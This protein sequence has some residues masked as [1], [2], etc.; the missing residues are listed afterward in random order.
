[1][2]RWVETVSGGSI[3]EICPFC[4]IVFCTDQNFCINKLYV[5]NQTKKITLFFWGL[6]GRNLHIAELGPFIHQQLLLWAGL[7]PHHT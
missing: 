2:S 5:Y 4:F 6:G 3:R 7:W 1:M